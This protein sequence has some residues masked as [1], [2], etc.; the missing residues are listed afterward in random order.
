MSKLSLLDKLKV[1][2][3]LSK[4]SR[5]YLIILLVLMIFGLILSITNKRNQKLNKKIYMI[6]TIMITIIMIVTYHSSL[7]KMISYMMDNLFIVVYF[8]NIAIYLGALI[9]MN[10]ILWISIFNF[11]SSNQIRGLNITIYIIMNYILALLLNVVNTNKLDIFNQASIYNNKEAS[12]LIGL[13][14]TIFA[15]WIIFLIIYKILLIYLKKD[16]KPK[17]KKIIIRKKVKKLPE[18]Y[19]P[20]RIPDFVYGNAPHIDSL[21]QMKNHKNEQLLQ[22]MD[23]KFTLEDYKLFSKMLKEQKESQLEIKIEEM[24]KEP[25]KEEVKEEINKVT[26]PIVEESKQEAKMVKIDD[27][28]IRTKRKL[29]ELEMLYRSVN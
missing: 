13:S 1:I 17:V 9:V 25:V 12:A 14:S 27:E 20:V 6:M 7:G 10:I 16:Y 24:K 3:D 18:N 11:K 21:V 23:N 15:V 4:E 2:I 26:I 19:E 28:D 22:E 29:T 8:P 5:V